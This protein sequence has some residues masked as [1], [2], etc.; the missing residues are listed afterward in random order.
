MSCL[1]ELNSECR[2]TKR[3]WESICSHF[4][5]SVKC[6]VMTMMQC[7]FNDFAGNHKLCYMRM[8]ERGP[9]EK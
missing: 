5:F 3:N 9:T 7:T 4:G 8:R 6:A 2:K 1:Y